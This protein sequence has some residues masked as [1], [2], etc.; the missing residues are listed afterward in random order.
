MTFS[1]SEGVKR[2]SDSPCG[3][4]EGIEFRDQMPSNNALG[5]RNA[6]SRGHGLAGERGL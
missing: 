4:N 1:V 2:N 3:N 5:G 6:E